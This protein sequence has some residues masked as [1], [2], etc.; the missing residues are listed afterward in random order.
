LYL[1]SSYTHHIVYNE[2]VMHK[3]HKLQAR[4][5]Y[6]GRFRVGLSYIV[7]LGLGKSRAGM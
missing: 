2:R 7:K 3:N 1:E 6:T 4:L 5:S